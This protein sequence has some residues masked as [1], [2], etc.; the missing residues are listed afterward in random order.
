MIVA[1]DQSGYSPSAL[2]LSEWDFARTRWR[3]NINTVG[4][5]PRS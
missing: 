2:V 1:A 5:M 3:T 4:S